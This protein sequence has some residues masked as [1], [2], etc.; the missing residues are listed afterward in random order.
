MPGGKKIER[1]HR[2]AFSDGLPPR[3]TSNFSKKRPGFGLSPAGT[4]KS[5]NADQIQ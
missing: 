5:F 1:S 3:D 4:D 2:V